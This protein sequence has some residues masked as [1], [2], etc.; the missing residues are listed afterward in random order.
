MVEDKLITPD[1]KEKLPAGNIYITGGSGLVGSRYIELN[2]FPS[3]FLTPRAKELNILDKNALEE[4]FERE[5]PGYALHVAA[6][7]DVAKAE[8][9]RG[10]ENSACWAINVEGTKNLAKM[11]KKYGVYL[12]HISTDMGFPG[13][14]EYPGPYSEDQDPENDFNKLTWYGYTK[15]Q[16]E[17]VVRDVMEDNYAI[18]RIIYPVRA[19]FEGKLD[20]LRKPLSLYDQ[21]KLYPMFNNQQVNICYIDELCVVIN[22]ILSE[23]RE[24]VYHVATKDVS[25]PYEIV[26]YLIE[27]ARGAG[28]AVKPSSIQDFIAEQ[29]AKNPGNKF[30]DVRYPIYGG[31]KV[32]KT[33]KELGVTFST[34]RQVIDKLIAQGLGK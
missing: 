26:S 15:A 27:K 11:C 23:K 2:C 17:S 28:N 34:T 19:K 4:F 22:K 10:D 7:T 25:T 1:I 8:E 16:A 14:S 18:V 9:Q 13:S 5:K 33:E 31:L 32:E 24:G 21:G 29:K 6:Y 12:L 30:I 3:N 20:Y